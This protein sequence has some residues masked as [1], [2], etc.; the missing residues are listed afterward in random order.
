MTKNGVY[1]LNLSFDELNN[2]KFELYDGNP[3][4]RPFGGST[5][6]ADPSVVT[7]DLAPDGKWHLFAHTLFGVYDFV[8]DDGIAFPERRRILSRA[9]R[10]DIKK[11]GGVFYLFYERTQPA[12]A[13][14]LTLA[15]ADWRSEIYVVESRDLKE[16]SAPRLVLGFDR[17]YEGAGRHGHSLS[18]PF[19]LEDGGRFRLY[20][21]AGLTFVKDCG[22]SEPTYICLAESDSVTGK[23]VKR[24]KPLFSPTGDD[25][26][27][28]LG[29]GC[30]KVYR[31]TDGYAALMNGIYSDG[32]KSGSAIVILRSDDGIAFTPVR[33]FLG[34]TDDGTGGWMEQFVYASHLVRHGDELR[35]YFNARDTADMLKGRECI[36]LFRAKL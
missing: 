21:S 22:F 30:I 11:V 12:F 6:V 28:G 13:R 3:L 20:Y 36:G 25:G 27:F 29:C 18:N 5:I 23:F 24:E 31:L 15:G 32:R 4:I 2:A 17:P 8:S 7:P 16:F 34:P 26:A 14:A 33:R 9:M 19:L 35:L 1:A 10:P